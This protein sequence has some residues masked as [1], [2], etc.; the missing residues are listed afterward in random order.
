MTHPLSTRILTIIQHE[1][2][3]S[4]FPA[5]PP[6]ITL[7][8][9]LRKD[10]RCCEIDYQSIALALDETFGIEIGDEFVEFD[11]AALWHTPGDIVRTVEALLGAVL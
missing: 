2:D 10:L 9:E 1:L 3:T 11:S 6:R 7:E 4:R 5:V 8:M